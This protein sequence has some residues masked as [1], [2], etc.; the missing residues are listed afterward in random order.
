MII[1]Y[2]IKDQR[3][4]CP[5]CDTPSSLT[6]K[7]HCDFQGS[8]L[9]NCSVCEHFFTW[10]E[11]TLEALKC[12][13][14]YIYGP[15]RN[16]YL[17]ST[18]Y[19]NVMIRRARAQVAFIKQWSK[20]GTALDI[21]CGIG[22]LTRQLCLKGWTAQGIDSDC[23]AIALGKRLFCANLMNRPISEIFQEHNLFDLICLSHV[24]EHLTDVRQA[25]DSIINILRPGGSIF[26]E[27]PNETT[28]P[29]GDLEGHI[30]FFSSRS[31]IRLINSTG[32]ELLEC[33]CCGP[34]H[35]NIVESPAQHISAPSRISQLSK[36]LT[37]TIL[38][39]TDWDGW[40]DKYYNDD[41]GTW[42][43]CIA[44]RK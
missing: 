17:S 35:A 18:V 34:V 16:N 31:L 5:I 42:I 10:P 14:E 36:Y 32:L 29:S 12:H 22:A 20:P 25:L 4:N 44:S 6:I 38:G 11:P 7:E 43:R 3:P 37:R 27:V 40:Y 15:N 8:S 21:G 33:K 19:R 9:Y 23:H 26:I 30:N 1:I 13:Y 41:T 2:P 24:L 28:C 39:I